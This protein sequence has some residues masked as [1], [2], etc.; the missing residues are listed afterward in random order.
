MNIQ[1]THTHTH[2]EIIIQQVKIAA[3]REKKNLTNTPLPCHSSFLTRFFFFLFLCFLSPRNP[4]RNDFSWSFEKSP[5]L[6]SDDERIQWFLPSASIQSCKCKQFHTRMRRRNNSKEN[7]NNFWA[8][9]V[10]FFFSGVSMFCSLPFFEF[11]NR[12]ATSLVY[13]PPSKKKKRNFSF[14]SPRKDLL[15]LW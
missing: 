1:Q 4:T 2:R 9:V 5:P 6:T 13:P 15:T 8:K 12:V 7:K 3:A 10:F 14:K 11:T